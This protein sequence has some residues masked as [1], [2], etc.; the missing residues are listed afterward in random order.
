MNE[1]TAE[2][3]QQTCTRF[4]YTLNIH[5]DHAGVDNFRRLIK[6]CE[7]IQILGL[8]EVADD[9]VRLVIGCTDE[10]TRDRL[11]DAW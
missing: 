11:R 9:H 7:E 6:A 1:I 5:V 10:V 3:P 4:P 2:M 8:D